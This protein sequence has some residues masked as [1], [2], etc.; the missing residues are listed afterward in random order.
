MV[1][2]LGWYEMK[3]FR[4]GLTHTDAP[5]SMISIGVSPVDLRHEGSDGTV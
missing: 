5:V 2:L 4:S 3:S 1:M